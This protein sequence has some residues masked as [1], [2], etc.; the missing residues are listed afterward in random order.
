MIDTEQIRKDAAELLLTP[1]IW[2]QRNRH[3]ELGIQRLPGLITRLIRAARPDCKEGAVDRDVRG[4]LG[5]AGLPVV[6]KRLGRGSSCEAAK[7]VAG[8][9]LDEVRGSEG[10]CLRLRIVKRKGQLVSQ[11]HKSYGDIQ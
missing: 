8:A 11:D 4:M 1:A 2:K 10:G 9:L 6:L 7:V 5:D 3:E